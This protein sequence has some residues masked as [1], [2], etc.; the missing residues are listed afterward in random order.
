MI[1]VTYEDI[2]TTQFGNRA[3]EQTGLPD[4]HPKHPL[5]LQGLCVPIFGSAWVESAPLSSDIQ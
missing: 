4:F 3:P 2:D 5:L 1:S